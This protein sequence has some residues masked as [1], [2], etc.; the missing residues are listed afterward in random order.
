[1][2][3]EPMAGTSGCSS[4]DSIL[5]FQPIRP[6]EALFRSLKTKC[7]C[8]FPVHFDSVKIIF[9]DEG[10]H[11]IH[12]FGPECGILYPLPESLAGKGQQDFEKSYSFQ[13]GAAIR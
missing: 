3:P 2:R 9:V 4:T 10:Y 12:K 6:V 1:M 8:C 13:L 7:D 5:F 11:E